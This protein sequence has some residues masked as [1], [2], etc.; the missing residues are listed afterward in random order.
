MTEQKR[1]R[2]HKGQSDAALA[3][4]RCER[5][6][7]SPSPRVHTP[8]SPLVW[9]RSDACI[10]LATLSS[11]PLQRTVTPTKPCSERNRVFH[12]RFTPSR[13]V[14][15]CSMIFAKASCF[16][17]ASSHSPLTGCPARG[18]GACD[19]PL[20][21][22]ARARPSRPP[23]QHPCRRPSQPLVFSS[24]RR[25]CRACAGTTAQVGTAWQ[26][27]PWCNGT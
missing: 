9:T 11:R 1:R 21:S 13:R 20:A 14:S 17:P 22:S 24:S 8:R 27:L 18:K 5:L 19:D 4:T 6:Q 3:A 16:A 15:T 10:R 23:R 25:R 2:E 12:F 26:C 7:R